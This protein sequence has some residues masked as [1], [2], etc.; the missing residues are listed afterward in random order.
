MWEQESNKYWKEKR[1]Q[2]FQKKVNDNK[3]SI[4]AGVAVVLL[5]V[6]GL[7]V[8]FMSASKGKPV[9]LSDEPIRYIRLRCR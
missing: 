5:L 2:S 4:V 6:V 7:V 3:T 9:V 8:Y 1:S